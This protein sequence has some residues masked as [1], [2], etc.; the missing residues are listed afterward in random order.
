MARIFLSYRREDTRADAGRLYDHL[1][2]R[3]GAAHIFMDVD[4][5]VA[6]DN[7][8]EKLKQTL[9]RC[10]TLLV[11][12]G[13]RWH[14]IA[15]ESGR[16]RLSL[17]GDYVRLEVETALTRGIVL[18]PVLVGGA[19]MPA[20]ADLPRQIA[21]VALRQAIELSDERFRDDIDRL[22]KAIARAR[23]ASSRPFARR[24]ATWGAS[25]LLAGVVVGAGYVYYARPA[26]RT[27]LRA[28][29]IELSHTQARTAIAEHGLYERDVNASGSGLAHDY[30]SRV[31]GEQV[32]VFDR[33]TGLVWQKGGSGSSITYPQAVE[34]VR[35]LNGANHAGETDWRLPTL[36]EA[37]S[38][39][40]P[41]RLGDYHLDPVFERG[42]A[43]YVWTSDFAADRRWVVYYRDGIAAM[44][45]PELNG[46][47]RAVRTQR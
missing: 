39:M 21:D 9:S 3:F 26:A 17:P 20:D 6:G 31:A 14:D 46:Y 27:T 43:P 16:P 47:V 15:D 2:E 28:D 40:E 34:Y 19:R 10:D 12:I 30:V 22:V 32:V 38:L 13:P 33:A 7:F 35:A 11:V 36:E 18:I 41:R 4:D 23:G 45:P 24:I 8:V 1:S 37:M 44:E 29:G 5:I 25:L 42:A